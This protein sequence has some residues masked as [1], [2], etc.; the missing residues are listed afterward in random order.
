[1]LS[2]C[3][4]H[5]FYTRKKCRLNDSSKVKHVISGGDNILNVCLLKLS[6]ISPPIYSCNRSILLPAFYPNNKRTLPNPQP[7]IDQH[8]QRMSCSGPR[9]LHQAFRGLSQ[10]FPFEGRGV[11]PSVPLVF[12]S[13]SLFLPTSLLNVHSPVAPDFAYLLNCSPPL[14]GNPHKDSDLFAVFLVV[15][16]G[17]FVLCTYQA[18]TNYT[19]VERMN[20]SVVSVRS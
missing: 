16:S 7:S 17:F 13:E 12:S 11:T 9:T 5:F 8:Y 18:F 3:S 20:D 10:N 15:S 4:H 6:T 14:E 19:S 1:M 2:S